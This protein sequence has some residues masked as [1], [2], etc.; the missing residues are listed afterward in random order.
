MNLVIIGNNTDE[1]AKDIWKGNTNYMILNQNPYMFG[2]AFAKFT[3]NKDVI[4]S[5]TS[6]Q[7]ESKTVDYVINWFKEHKYIPIFI[8]DDKESMER[9]MHIAMEESIPSSILYTRNEKNK[10]YDVL[11]KIARGYL[12][13]K[14]IIEDD[15][16]TL[17]T[18][19]E[20]E[21]SATQE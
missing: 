6:E 2:P 8:A 20:G 15:D 13:G 12:L 16:K 19:G 18:P 5:T 10:D 3:E 14:G 17:R 1:I 9:K 11:V 4:I 7:F 21:T